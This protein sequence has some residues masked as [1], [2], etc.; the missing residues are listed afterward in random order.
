MFRE[1]L[2]TMA[3]GFDIRPDY[4]TAF[5]EWLFDEMARVESRGRLVR[6]L[7]STPEGR[8]IGWY[9][10]YFKAGVSEVIQVM[11][12]DRDT[13]S[14]LDH[15]FRDAYDAGASALRGR[16]EGRL[17]TALWGRGCALRYG[18]AALAQADDPAIIHAVSGGRALLTRLDGEWWMGHHTE[19][20][21]RRT[22]RNG[23]SSARRLRAEVVDDVEALRDDWSRLAEES[24]NVFSSWEWNVLWWRR[25]GA[26]R[27]AAIV[28][29]R[30]AGGTARAIVPLYRWTRLPLTV[31][32]FLGHGHG[33]LLGPICAREPDVWAEAL[34]VALDAVRC[35]I[36][37]G[38]LMPGDRRRPP[39]LAGKV[40]SQTGYP[41][42]EF[43][44]ASWEERT[45]A[46]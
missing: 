33:D 45:S 34:E 20:F 35:D 24:R 16:L 37:V 4:E 38:D 2:P 27:R 40:L 28:V 32:R 43:H 15:L 11:S 13:G 41:I 42:L 21:E 3:H 6:T 25:F 29:C 31:L 18:V 5:L 9:V 1:L 44:G 22:S 8:P 7:V 12:L 19:A 39:G 14:V 26:G 10:A 30:D 17:L 46:A 36:L 23:A